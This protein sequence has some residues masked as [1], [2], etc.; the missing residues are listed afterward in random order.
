MF[1]IFILFILFLIPTSALSEDITCHI[2]NG[3]TVFFKTNSTIIYISYVIEKTEVIITRDLSDTEVK[4]LNK[5]TG[6]DFTGSKNLLARNITIF[7]LFHGS[8]TYKDMVIVV[9]KK[10][11]ICV[12]L[13]I[14]GRNH[15]SENVNE[16]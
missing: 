8:H 1:I 4:N 16:V 3:T 5:A 2:K 10:D 12:L 15:G 6:L 13:L 9:L 14:K 7:C 11:L